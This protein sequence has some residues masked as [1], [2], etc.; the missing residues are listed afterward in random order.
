M[1]TSAYAYEQ[2][3]PILIENIHATS[4]DPYIIEDFEISSD[5]ANCIEVRNSEHVIIRNNYLHDCNW[6]VDDPL[7]WTE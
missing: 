6:S 5:K 1:I 7:S 4:E 3:E 2:H